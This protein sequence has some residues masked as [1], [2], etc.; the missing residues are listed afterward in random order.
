M[1]NTSQGLSI[2]DECPHV[3][4]FDDADRKPL[5][6]AGTGAR[7]GALKAWEQVS[8]SWNAHLFVRVESNTRDDI[9]PSA[10]QHQASSGEDDQKHSRDELMSMIS[11]L[12]NEVERLN[13][14]VRDCVDDDMEDPDIEIELC[15]ETD[16]LVARARTL[17]GMASGPGDQ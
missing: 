16:Q 14:C 17:I 8:K 13:E 1:S 10:T 7:K 5:H 11:L 2:P 3:I 9:Y 12:A 6:F 4:F 15:D